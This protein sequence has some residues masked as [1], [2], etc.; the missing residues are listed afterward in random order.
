M[1]NFY[2]FYRYSLATNFKGYKK[3]GSGLH[4]SGQTASYNLSL[5][6]PVASEQFPIKQKTAE[7]SKIISAVFV[8]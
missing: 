4:L 1:D 6:C 3:A 2:Y 7:I 8:L 5:L